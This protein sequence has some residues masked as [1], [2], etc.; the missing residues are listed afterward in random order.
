MAKHEIDR[1][2]YPTLLSWAISKT[3]E[4]E[5]TDGD[6]SE[7]LKQLVETEQPIIQPNP[8]RSCLCGGK[9]QNPLKNLEIYK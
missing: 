7:V 3:K 4:L 5:E 8:L 2:S 1:K 6:K 9:V